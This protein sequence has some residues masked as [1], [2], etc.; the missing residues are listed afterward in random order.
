[1]AAL[2]A[3][4]AVKAERMDE[5]NGM[6]EEMQEVG[7]ISIKC[8]VEWREEEEEEEADTIRADVRVKQELEEEEITP[9][10]LMVAANEHHRLQVLYCTAW[11]KT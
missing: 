3:G 11:N 4:E 2:P 8:E 9:N 5:A 1:M 7:N 10:A 6:E